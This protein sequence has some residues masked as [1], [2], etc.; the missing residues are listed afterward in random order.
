[1]RPLLIFERLPKTLLSR[2]LEGK[3]QEIVTFS[4]MDAY[5]GVTWA[6]STRKSGRLFAESRE[7]IPNE[8]MAKI[9]TQKAQLSRAIMGQQSALSDV[10]SLRMASATDYV[11]LKGVRLVSAPEDVHLFREP[12]AAPLSCAASFSSTTVVQQ[13]GKA[14][15]GVTYK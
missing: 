6:T 7:N 2:R 12:C 3:E 15:S 11:K 4:L 14:D 1:M 9:L 5:V 13:A 8:E 10:G